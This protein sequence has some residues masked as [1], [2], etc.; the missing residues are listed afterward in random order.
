MNNELT[1]NEIIEEIKKIKIPSFVTKTEKYFFKIGRYIMIFGFLSFVPLAIIYS[2]INNI[3]TSEI[4]WNWMLIWFGVLIIGNAL[5]MLIS[6]IIENI[7]VIKQ[8]KKLGI[9]RSDFVKYATMLGIKSYP[10]D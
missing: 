5:L 1:T 3:N 7:F 8:A 10:G 4:M 6:H 2:N 9:S